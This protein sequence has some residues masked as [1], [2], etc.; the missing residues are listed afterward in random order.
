[1]TPFLFLVEQSSGISL[2]IG[3]AIG[4]GGGIAAVSILLGTL[5]KAYTVK[6]AGETKTDVVSIREETGRIKHARELDKEERDRESTVAERQL[7][8]MA[9]E[10]HRERTLRLNDTTALEFQYQQLGALTAENSIYKEE[11]EALLAERQVTLER[12]SRV[13][14]Q[15]EECHDGHAAMSHN[16]RMTNEYIKELITWVQSSFEP[17]SARTTLKPPPEK[18]RFT[19]PFDT[20]AVG[21]EKKST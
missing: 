5:L 14:K 7:E 1:M 19:P 10:L 16:L 21:I 6:S 8:R 18:P 2:S 20:P 17:S 9:Q 3:E 13:E 11:K 12:L 15:L 4:G